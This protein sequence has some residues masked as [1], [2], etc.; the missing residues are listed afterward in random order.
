VHRPFAPPQPVLTLS[1][2]WPHGRMS[3]AARSFLIVVAELTAALDVAT[4]FRARLFCP[5][6]GVDR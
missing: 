5:D 6:D 4:D 3:T 1:L 2:A